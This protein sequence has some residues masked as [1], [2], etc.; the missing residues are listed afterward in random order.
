M[1]F[2][3]SPTTRP[4]SHVNRQLV[5]TVLAHVMHLEFILFYL[6]VANGTDSDLILSV[7]DT[8]YLVLIP[9][10]VVKTKSMLTYRSEFGTPMEGLCWVASGP[11]LV[12]WF[13]GAYI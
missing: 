7:Y 13:V 9:E 11:G 4:Y 5:P 2:N 6:E 12:G 8:N 3:K 10:Q 1:N